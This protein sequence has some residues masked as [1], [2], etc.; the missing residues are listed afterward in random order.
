MSHDTTQ[1]TRDSQTPLRV[2]II[3]GGISGLAAAYYLTQDN[4]PPCEVVIYEATDHLGGNAYTVQVDLGERRDVLLTATD[5]SP[6][7]FTRWADLGVDDFNLDTYTHIKAIMEE[8]DFTDYLPLEDTVSFFT[9]DGSK[10]VL[11]A[12]NEL[13]QGASN[14]QT[15]ISDKLDKA[16][17]AF[18]QAAAEA[19]GKPKYHRWTVQQFVDEYRSEG[20]YPHAAALVDTLR[21]DLLYPRI[22]AMY[23]VDDSG[24]E[25]M[26][27]RAV[28]NYYI[29]QEGFKSGANQAPS[30]DRNY[31]VEGAESWIRCLA[32]WLEKHRKVSFI[33][34]ARAVVSAT[35][36]K[37]SVSLPPQAGL[38]GM[39]EDEH[40]DKVVMATHADDALRSIHEGATKDIADVL[41]RVRYSNSRAVAHTFADLL[42][43]DRNAWRTYNVIIRKGISLKPYR[44]TYVMNRLQ[45][46]AAQWVEDGPNGYPV[47]KTSPYNRFGLPQFFVSLNPATPVP[48]KYVLRVIRQPGHTPGGYA[49]HFSEDEQRL[50]GWHAIDKEDDRATAWFKH[51]VLDFNCLDAQEKLDSAQ[52]GAH[53][54]LYFTGGWCKGAGL[55]EECWLM[56]EHV[57]K[58]VFGE[59]AKDEHC[60]DPEATTEADYVPRYWREV[61]KT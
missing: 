12:D 19:V 38:C 41:G 13:R 23:F 35:S 46:D 3:G 22:S 6:R 20:K 5:A 15:R 32:D 29:L 24:P 9:R 1:S 58:R 61:H 16:Y 43:A 4:R 57:A 53:G 26:P 30:P 49:K 40:F 27:L 34:N 42:P 17:Q 39:R 51:N 7:T 10:K 48:D 28:M 11:T 18:M 54:N 37:V 52:G 56:G 8:I 45:N 21:D 2:A 33:C 55:H 60:F 14:P 47:I 59:S 44:M 50:P 31:F 36:D 25:H